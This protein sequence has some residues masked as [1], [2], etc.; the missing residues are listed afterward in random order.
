[1]EN[2]LNCPCCGN[3]SFDNYINSRDFA[4]SREEF[5]II[6]CLECTLLL[7]SPRPI[8]SEAGKYY[9]FENYI[10]HSNKSKGLFASLY[11]SARKL[12]LK[13]KVNLI[14]KYKPL[15]GFLLDI[16]CGTGEFINEAKNINWTVKG[17]EP[18]TNARNFGISEYNL[19]IEDSATLD[20]LKKN[21][22]DV[23]SMWH[24]LEHVYDLNKYIDTI[25]SLLKSD[26]IAIIAVPNATS[27]DAI[28]Y[29]DKWAGLDLPRH[30]WHFTPEVMEKLFAKHGFR[31]VEQ[32][33]QFFDPF[34]VSLLSE[35]YKGNILSYPFAMVLGLY[36]N[37]KSL[38]NTKH[39][40]SLIY[41]FKKK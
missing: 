26:G 19:E 27:S 18:D 30:I 8:E 35:K 25:Y 39:S 14:N 33:I 6:K 32:K 37:F 21:E 13:A 2:V 15:K 10:S 16:G 5:S 12:N 34:Y 41:V 9:A 24:V 36:F 4:N 1:M 31:L 7:T 23:V 11:Q 38:L 28:Y 3:S 40:S 17:V 20:S 22:V 29:G